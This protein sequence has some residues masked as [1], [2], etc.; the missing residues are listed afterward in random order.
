MWW[1][2][3]LKLCEREREG[4]EEKKAGTSTNGEK[5]CQ[6]FGSL[7]EQQQQMYRLVGYLSIMCWKW[8]E[9]ILFKSDIKSIAKS[10]LFFVWLKTMWL[11]LANTIQ[12]WPFII[13]S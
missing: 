11:S 10:F 7:T 8:E 2:D 4:K 6:Q 3:S 12:F 5:Q 13:I 9:N 1:N